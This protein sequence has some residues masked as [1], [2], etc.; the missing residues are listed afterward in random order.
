ME[1]YEEPLDARASPI[2]FRVWRHHTKKSGAMVRAHS[3]PDVEINFLTR[4]H[5]RYAFGGAMVSVTPGRLAV[6]WGS[7]PHQAVELGP[8][9]IGVWLTVPLPLLLSW[10]LPNKIE[11]RLLQ[12]EFIQSRHTDEAAQRDTLLLQRWPDDFQREDAE[13][14]RT[15]M[16][17]IEARL[18][19]LAQEA[20]RPLARKRAE[21][22][23]PGIESALAFLHAHYRD[24]VHATDAAQ[25]AG[26]DVKYLMRKFK[27]T[28]NVSVGEYLSRLRIS[29]AQWL[30]IA[31]DKSVLEI[32]FE[33]GYQSAAPFYQA[34]ARANHG[35][36]PLKYR[37]HTRSTTL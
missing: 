3:H 4:G 37:K 28:L 20:P 12:G 27:S 8:E 11:D 34:F 30:L 15:L 25:A 9:C 23:G 2:G 26:W 16:L 1:A 7:I 18:R 35:V 13:T 5:V 14:Q 33:S 31:T 24:D 32:A 17:E 10:K 6:F 29:H 22:P 36:T 21:P 19:R